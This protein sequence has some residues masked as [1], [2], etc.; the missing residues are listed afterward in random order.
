MLKQM[1]RYKRIALLAL[2]PLGLLLTLLARWNNGWVENF[3]SRY[4]YPFF[5]NTIGW[6]LSLVPFSVLEILLITGGGAVLFYIAWQIAGAIRKPEGRKDRLARLVWNL[7][8][9]ASVIYF[10]FVLFMGLNYYRDP[11]AVHLDLR[12][13]EATKQ[14]LFDLCK[15]LAA[16]CNTYRAQLQEGPDGVALLQDEN[17]YQTADAAKEAYA[18]LEAEVPLL[19]AADIRNKP[20]MTSRLFSMAL[21]TGIYIPFESGINTDA[22][23]HSVPATMCHELT[24]FRGFMREEEANFIGYLA[25]MRSDRADFRY[26]ASLLAFTYAFSDLVAEDVELARQIAALCGEGMLRD[27]QAEDDY[28]NQFRGTAFGDASQ[29]IYGEYLQA[30]G[31]ESGLASYSEM[32]ELLIAYRNR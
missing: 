21:T 12:V 8:G 20:L 18:A 29:V 1:F 3:H 23:A 19:R 10:G 5:A 17:Y 4:I 27:L 22:P 26:S 13:E 31:Q 24:H 14:D 28:W 2:A 7:L 16:D 32:V 15:D 30:N 9:G 6:L 25:C 11:I